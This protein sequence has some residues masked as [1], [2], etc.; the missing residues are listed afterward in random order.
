MKKGLILSMSFLLVLTSCG[1]AGAGMTV[2][3]EF[4]YIIGSSIGGISDGWRGHHVGGLIGTVGGA[5]AG[6][7]IGAAVD[8]SQQRKYEEAMQ[9]RER[10]MEARRE[11]RQQQRDWHLSTEQV[12]QSGFD[13][14]MRGDD[15]ITFDDNAFDRRPNSVH[16]PDI[17]LRHAT[18]ADAD[19]NGVLVRGEECTVMFE[20]MNN[21]LAVVTDIFPFVENVTANKHVKVSPNL[22]VE[23]IPPYQGIRYTATIRADKK[24]KDGEIVVRVGVSQGQK[25]II[26]SQTQE[27][28]MR[29]ARK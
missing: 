26:A 18:I 15:R 29:T 9:Q 11:Q 7:A 24:L 19:G 28:T 17:E 14:D 22:R 5:V 6:A 10:D 27:F 23:S 2:G 4:G 8:A 20:V 25:G 16:R 13:P 21:T 3:G 1:S 12:D